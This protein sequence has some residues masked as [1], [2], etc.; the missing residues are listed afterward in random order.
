MLK[1]KYRLVTLFVTTFLSCGAMAAEHID[2]LVVARI[3]MDSQLAVL[4]TT[5]QPA[6]TCNWHGEF[7]VFD[8]T[9]SA[10][11]SFLGTL[12]TAKASGRTISVWYTASG[13]P[14][15]NASNGCTATTVSTLIAVAI[16]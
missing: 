16:N 10:G 13:A 9:T 15:T 4:G 7:F 6:N 1:T 12:L 11:K 14:G 8:H 3:R 5:T 2:S